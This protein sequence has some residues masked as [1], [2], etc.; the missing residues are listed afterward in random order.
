MVDKIG[1]RVVKKP[2]DR[3]SNPQ[4]ARSSRAGRAKSNQWLIVNMPT[5][6]LKHFSFLLD[7]GGFFYSFVRL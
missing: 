4:V 2:M 7:L 6:C 5:P 1:K 3:T